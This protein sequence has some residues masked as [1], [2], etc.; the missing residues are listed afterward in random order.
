MKILVV[1]AHADDIVHSVAGTLMS[2]PDD[3]LSIL[4][5][6]P[7]LQRSAEEVAAALGAS[8]HFLDGPYHEIDRHTVRLTDAA[9]EYMKQLLPDYV[10]APPTEGDW[11]SDHTTTGEISIAAASNSGTFG[12]SSPRILRYPVPG[13]TTRFSPN[14]WIALQ[15][16]LIARKTELAALMTRGTED[17]W[18]RGLVD[19]E[20]AYGARFANQLGWPITHAE[21]FDALYPVPFPHLPP[22]DGATAHLDTAH[23]EMMAELRSGMDLSGP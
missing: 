6:V 17:V 9:T 3:E 21:A 23:R 22:P 14:V 12:A 8:I 16:G 10:F 1:C 20:I 4:S 5:I 11:S 19:W 15:A 2:H 18:T 13:S 7:Y